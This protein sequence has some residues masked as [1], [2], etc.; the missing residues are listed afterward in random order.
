VGRTSRTKVGV[1]VSNDVE[2]LVPNPVSFIVQKLLIH[3]DR[4]SLKK[5]QDVL[6]IH[7]TVELFGPAMDELQ[8]LWANRVRPAM[9]SKTAARAARIAI[10]LFH[11]VTDTIREAAR[12]PKT[13]IQRPST[14][15][16]LA[17]T[18]WAKSSGRASLPDVCPLA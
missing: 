2:L 7:D 13:D 18:A 8:G 16:W 4:N 15:E 1:P 17:S 14:S 12:M 3:S 9:P 5:A 11:E 6:Y 10:E